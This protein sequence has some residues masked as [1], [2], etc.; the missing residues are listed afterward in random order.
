VDWQINW[1]MVFLIVAIQN[2][3]KLSSEYSLFPVN[4]AN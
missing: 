2:L 1:V 4:I 3:G